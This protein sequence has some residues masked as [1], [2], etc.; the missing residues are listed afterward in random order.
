MCLLGSALEAVGRIYREH[1][2]SYF[3]LQGS[4]DEVV[5]ILRAYCA[6]VTED[7]EKAE[8]K[9]RH[10]ATALQPSFRQLAHNRQ[11]G[12]NLKIEVEPVSLNKSR[13]IIQRDGYA[14]G[15]TMPQRTSV[16]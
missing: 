7:E 10:H 14:R 6:V 12:R 16:I 3:A 1:Y 8:E 13:M 4:N 9:M 11:A 5:C 15:V 2:V